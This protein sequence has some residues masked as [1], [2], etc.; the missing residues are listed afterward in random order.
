MSDKGTIGCGI[1]IVAV[2]AFFIWAMSQALTPVEITVNGKVASSYGLLNR[3]ARYR[4][5]VVY[6][7]PFDHVVI[8]IICIE[9]IIVPAWYVGYNLWVPVGPKK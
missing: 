9:T 1:A 8:P 4:D 6:E 7:V 2:I 5:D 3:D